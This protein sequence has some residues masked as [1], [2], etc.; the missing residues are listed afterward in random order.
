MWSLFKALRARD[1]GA[2]K[3]MREPNAGD[4]EYQLDFLW[5]NKEV[6]PFPREILRK[7]LCVDDMNEFTSVIGGYDGKTDLYTSL[8][9]DWQM[10][11]NI[12]DCVFFEI[13]CYTEVGE[14]VKDLIRMA[15]VVETFLGEQE[16]WFRRFFSGKKGFHYYIAFPPT[17]FHYFSNAVRKW[18]EKMPKVERINMQKYWYTG[19]VETIK[20]WAFDPRTIGNTKQLVRIPGTKHPKTNLYCLETYGRITI[21]MK[22]RREHWLPEEN[23]KF[24]KSLKLRD[25]KPD[26]VDR[27]S[28]LIDFNF[29]E[30]PRCIRNAL[31][32]MR[33]HLTH[34]QAWHLANFMVTLGATDDEIL[35]CMM[36][37]PRYNE[38]LARPQIESIRSSGLANMSCD[39][40]SFNSMCD[41]KQKLTC[42]MWPSI[43]RY[44]FGQDGT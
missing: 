12:F 22:G 21:P 43:D 39:K 30:S 14:D 35:S 11:N 2:I 24:M 42:P 44:L 40:I 33:G 41:E 38:A 16:I 7:R 34:D 32:M 15:E 20:T 8:Y 4:R 9:N 5:R 28:G 18:A 25:R 3:T 29:A 19:D 27:T 6:Y 31:Q 26:V 13:D 37:D 36:I 10:K 17:H 23:I 1:N